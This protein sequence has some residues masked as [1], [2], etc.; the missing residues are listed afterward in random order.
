MVTAIKSVVYVLALLIL[1]LYVF[2]IAFKQLSSPYEFHSAFFE[3]IPLAMYSLFIYCT[4]LDDLAYFGDSIRFESPECYLLSLVF[5]MLGSMTVMNMLVGVL[6]EVVGGVAVTEREEMAAEKAR[7][8]LEA[9]V[10]TLDTDK[11]KKISYK[12][13]RAIFG[14]GEAL[15]SLQDID[16]DP[17]RIVDFAEHFF[18]KDGEVVELP[19][20]EFMQMLLKLRS[21]NTATVAEIMSVWKNSKPKLELYEQDITK[22]GESLNVMLKHIQDTKAKKLAMEKKL[23]QVL[24]TLE[25]IKNA[26]SA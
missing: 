8:N 10:D 7:F 12:E 16:V 1:F 3:S 24:Q 25:K 11:N 2:G 23:D 5:I 21:T 17:V 4:F 9:I 15:T 22:L 26:K 19:F 18:V 13:Y 20:E 14:F 6:C